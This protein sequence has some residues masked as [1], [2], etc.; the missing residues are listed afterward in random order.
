[1]AKH[2]TLQVFTFLFFRIFPKKWTRSEKLNK[3]SSHYAGWTALQ[4]QWSVKLF[5]WTLIRFQHAFAQA[6]REWRDLDQFVV[7]NE[8]ESAF[9]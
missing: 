4:S 1:M 2:K 8:F 5:F 6:D 3:V 9:E 7:G